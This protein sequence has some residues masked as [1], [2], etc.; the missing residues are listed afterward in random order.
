MNEFEGIAVSDDEA[1]L[2]ASVPAEWVRDQ[3]RL[4]GK[5]LR[6]EA[7]ALK[8]LEDSI[9]ALRFATTD[10]ADICEKQSDASLIP[11]MDRVKLARQDKITQVQ[12]VQEARNAFTRTEVATGAHIA[13]LT[14]LAPA[15]VEGVASN[16]IDETVAPP[17]TRASRDSGRIKRQ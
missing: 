10:Y 6:G 12:L 17:R 5:G 16:Q 3:L 2:A 7:A 8:L 11:T 13:R 1:V 14:A 9:R 4:V 15:W